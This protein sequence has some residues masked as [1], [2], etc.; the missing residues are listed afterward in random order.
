MR[1]F[2][3][4]LVLLHHSAT[5]G[6]KY[7]LFDLENVGLFRNGANAV[8]F[9][10]VLSG[11]L[12]TYLLQKEQSQTHN[13]NI[14]QFYLRRIRRIWPL[15]FLLIAIGTIFL[16]LAISI[17]GLDYQMPYSIGQTWYYFLFFLPDYGSS[18]LRSSSFRTPL[19][20]RGRRDFL[21]DVGSAC[22]I[23]QEAFARGHICN[24]G[25]EDCD[26]SCGILFFRFFECVLSFGVQLQ[27]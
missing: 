22:Q 5:I 11:F 4:F 12:I 1:F 19:V 15:Y 2:F 13:I 8:N 21:S 10:F 24:H 27:F 18:H 17:S 7:G 25:I 16:P 3:F 23:L 9:F 6:R 20:D 14:K 26:G